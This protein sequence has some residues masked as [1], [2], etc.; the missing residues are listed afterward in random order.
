MLLDK[1]RVV[2]FTKTSQRPGSVNVIAQRQLTTA[3]GA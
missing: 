1:C 2:E 3:S